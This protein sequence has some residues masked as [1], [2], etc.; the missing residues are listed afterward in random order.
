MIDLGKKLRDLLDDGWVPGSERRFDLWEEDYGVKL[1]PVFRLFKDYYFRHEIRN[2]ERL[3]DRG[4]ALMILNHGLFSIDPIFLGMELWERKHRIL[5]SLSDRRAF[6]IP[7]LRQ[8]YL[9][10]GVV[11]GHR[12]MTIEML[13]HG[14][15]CF[16]MPGGGLEWGKSSAR[17]YE[18]LWEDHTGF[19]ITALRAEVPII[20]IATIG[21]D[22]V[23][24]IPLSIRSKAFGGVV[25]V[26][27]FVYGWGPL[28]RPVKLVQYVG[29][30]IDFNEM[31]Y[32][33]ADAENSGTVKKLQVLVRDSLARMLEDGLE[34]RT[35]KWW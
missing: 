24:T 23:F 9:K 10:M 35:S 27:L 1:F 12:E 11:E 14:E 19:I 33:P 18:L 25:R 3:P 31:G 28:P 8:A 13:K 4:G 29:E 7:Y 22:D 20:P 21:T 17:K 2:F 34:E 15:L 16:A 26:P 6:K 30:P 5:R 32:T